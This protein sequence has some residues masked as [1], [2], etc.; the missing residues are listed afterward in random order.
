MNIKRTLV[1]TDSSHNNDAALSLGNEVT[2][3]LMVIAGMII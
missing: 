3:G 2:G 1:P